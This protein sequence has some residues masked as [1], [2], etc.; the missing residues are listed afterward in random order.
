[1]INTV[2]A[3]HQPHR[4]LGRLKA[5]FAVSTLRTFGL[6]FVGL[7]LPILVYLSY[8]EQGERIAVMMMVVFYLIHQTLQLLAVPLVTML[9]RTVGTRGTLAVSLICVLFFL[10]FA[11]REMYLPAFIFA[12]GMDLLWW[13]PYHY[14]FVRKSSSQD[15]GKQVSVMELLFILSASIA[16]LAG[17]L[18]LTFANDTILYA[19]GGLITLGAIA[20]VYFMDEPRRMHAVSF[21]ATLAEYRR[22]PTD[23]LAFIGAGAEETLNL[24]VWP[25]ILYF[26]FGDF[27]SIG[28]FYAAV[29]LFV[30]GINLFLG[31]RLDRKKDGAKME[32]IG[33]WGLFIV[34]LGRA[35]FPYPVSVTFLEI[36]YKILYAFFRL[37]LTAIAYFHSKHD[38]EQYLSYRQ[39]GYKIGAIIIL[40]IF[41]LIMYLGYP[42][43]LILIVA[44]LFA[45]L[46]ARIADEAR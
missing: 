36:A 6:T 25:L 35:A 4:K 9:A 43:W 14:Y 5:F 19:I 41:A 16:P 1:M 34:W 40:S 10:Y 30:A 44:G 31:S 15:M 32:K 38:R 39:L 27:L 8:I 33:A 29:I 2:N 12:A 42:M 37:P 20:T 28:I 11:A 13:F 7:F 21:R 24:I 17:G 3:A 46:P 18:V 23:G 45:L 26:V 22:F